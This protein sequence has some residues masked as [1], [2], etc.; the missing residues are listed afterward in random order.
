MIRTNMKALTLIMGNIP[1]ENKAQPLRLQRFGF[2]NIKMTAVFLIAPKNR[3]PQS[4][5]RHSAHRQCSSVSTMTAPVRADYDWQLAHERGRVCVETLLSINNRGRGVDRVMSQNQTAWFET[6]KHKE[7]KKKTLDGFLSFYD[8]CVQALPTH[9][10]VQS[11]CKS[12]C[13][14]IW[15]L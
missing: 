11:T 14:I 7:I 1:F 6:G 2:R 10:S 5:R 3:T 13:T 4:L 9:I 12:A 8:G 15:P